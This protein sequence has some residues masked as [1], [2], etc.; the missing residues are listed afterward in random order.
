MTLTLEI[1]FLSDWHVGQ[2]SGRPGAIDRLVRRDAD[3][4]P[5]V[6]ARTLLGVWRDSAESLAAALD[7]CGATTAWTTLVSQLFGD[8]PALR[9]AT[10]C[11]PGRIR[12][13]PAR[14]L[15]EA[16]RQALANPALRDGLTF[17]SP[18]VRVDPKTGAAEDDK[19]YFTELCPAGAT[20]RAE[21]ELLS[22][23]ELEEGAIELL[24]LAASAEGVR[25]IGGKRRRGRGACRV[26]VAEV[27][28]A[29]E[30]LF[31]AIERGAAPRDLAHRGGSP[32]GQPVPGEGDTWSQWR[33][34]LLARDPLLIHKQTLG[35]VIESLDR[36]PGA[37]LLPVLDRALR[38]RGHSL[39][40][41]IEG[42][43]LLVRDA[44]LVERDTGER[45]MPLPR[46]WHRS[47]KGDD[48]ASSFH[49]RA[50]GELPQPRVVCD[51]Y[52]SASGMTT[53]ER[54][55]VTHAHKVGQVVQTHN[56]IS[57]EEQRPTEAV[58]GVYS[59]QAIASGTRLAAVVLARGAALVAAVDAGL[60]ALN[61]KKARMGR[62]VRADYGEVEIGVSPMQTPGTM[63][64]RDGDLTLWLA[65]PLLVRDA[66]LR[67]STDPGDV[68]R[69]LAGFGLECASFDTEH[70]RFST[71]RVESWH[72]GWGL[73]RPS[74]VGFAPGSVLVF[75]LAQPASKESLDRL[76]IEGL[77]ERRAEGY[78]ELVVNPEAVRAAPRHVDADA[79]IPPAAPLT[80]DHVATLLDT[81]FGTTVLRRAIEADL[82]RLATGKDLPMSRKI[83]GALRSA[84]LTAAPDAARETICTWAERAKS[85]ATVQW[86]QGFDWTTEL[87]PDSP[88]RKSV[89]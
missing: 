80:A 36:V 57:D 71:E 13:T 42:G 33:V 50:L 68:A 74:L 29:T 26:R 2:G 70:S 27:E 76:A 25:A 39:G 87:H 52:V 88:D 18:S 64:G 9:G 41:A 46:S 44:R 14:V 38:A 20:L 35:N 79:E 54:L 78:G 63:V 31:A 85:R 48:W 77:G 11:E 49:A 23:A 32:D 59:Y 72:T 15:P 66:A 24:F 84:A 55:D 16:L 12:L 58:G 34:E 51:R 81:P 28:G 53:D 65:S 3:G 73:P 82:R 75:R 4:L 56:V 61:G 10:R 17:T 62:A 83:A 5:Y 37:M 86:I 6:P 60:G 7:L 8:Q 22:L 40:Q 67:P 89:V 19:L 45:L 69:L 21:A 1:T 43:H 47:K 30:A